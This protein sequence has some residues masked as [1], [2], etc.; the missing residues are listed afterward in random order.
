MVARGIAMRKR[1]LLVDCEWQLLVYAMGT[2]RRA[3]YDVLAESDGA[4]ALAL[5]DRWHPHLVI[6]PSGV[7][8]AWQKQAPE[9]LGSLLPASSLLITAKSDDPDRLWH[10]W[11]AQGYEILFKPVVHQ[12]ELQ[13]A[14]EAA[15]SAS[16]VPGGMS[17]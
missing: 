5:V 3:G 6:A 16:S 17:V 15:M 4:A 12:L 9:G 14:I 2:L 10:R 13:T 11:A 1:I 7:I 8:S